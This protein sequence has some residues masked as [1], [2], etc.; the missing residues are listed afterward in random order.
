[1]TAHKMAIIAKHQGKGFSH[2]LMEACEKWAKDKGAT[3]MVIL[4][5]SDLSSALN[6]Y[7]KHGY[8]AVPTNGIISP[9]YARC[10]LK[11]EKN[12]K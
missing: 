5:N 6:L 11:L 12:L 2:P 8:Q 9:D 1:M 7:K 3:K 4:T 10:D